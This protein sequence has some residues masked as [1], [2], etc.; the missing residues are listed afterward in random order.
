MYYFYLRIYEIRP[1]PSS[2]KEPS[3]IGAIF[4]RRVLE[5]ESFPSGNFS[6]HETLSIVTVFGQN[7][8]RLKNRVKDVAEGKPRPRGIDIQ[9]NYRDC[10]C[11]GARMTD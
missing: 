4:F 2:S 1:L 10:V 6:L 7:R 11:T 8:P 3:S 5:L 9:R